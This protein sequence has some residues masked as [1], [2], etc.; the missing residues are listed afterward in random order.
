MNELNVVCWLDNFL[1]TAS[2]RATWERLC[3][4]MRIRK[5]TKSN[6]ATSPEK[7]RRLSHSELRT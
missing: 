3:S 5:V 7:R 2:G 4:F 6:S 1:T